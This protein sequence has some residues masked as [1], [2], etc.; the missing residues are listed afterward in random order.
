MSESAGLIAWRLA[1]QQSPIVLQGGIT[2]LLGGYLPIMAITELI[3]LPLGLLGT[4]Q[5]NPNTFFA[6]FEPMDG[7]SILSQAI[8][9]FPL[10]NQQ[11]AANATIQQPL[12]IGMKMV[13]PVINTFGFYERLALIMALQALLKSQNTSG[14][15][16]IVATPS[17]IY[18]NCLF[19][20]MRQANSAE[21]NQPQN[22]WVLEFEQPL[23]TLSDVQA[24]AG[25]LFSQISAGLGV[26]QNPAFSGAA[27]AVGQ[28]VSVAAPS[29]VGTAAVSPATITVTPLPP[30]PGY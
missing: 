26:G 3:N 22:T 25:S 18:T 28:S 27:Q 11:I 19:K 7:T 21:S 29:V 16:Y 2:T 14:G 17:F 1:F 10:A 5:V 30:P 4:G 15:T 6:N 8:A 23:L 9:H 20:E 13:C 12:V 24:S